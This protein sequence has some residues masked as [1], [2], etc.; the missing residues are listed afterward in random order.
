MNTPTLGSLRTEVAGLSTV[1]HMH[2]P[3]SLQKGKVSGILSQDIHLGGWL[4]DLE[5]WELRVPANIP[6]TVTWVGAVVYKRNAEGLDWIFSKL[7]QCLKSN[8]MNIVGGL[9]FCCQT[10]KEDRSGDVIIYGQHKYAQI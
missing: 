5:F 1:S 6:L 2:S 3:V 9:G 7:N 4:V 10:N 8:F